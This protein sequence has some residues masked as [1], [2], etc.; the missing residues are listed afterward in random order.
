MT[1]NTK[2]KIEKPYVSLSKS[3]EES[4]IDLLSRASPLQLAR[5]YS[6]RVLLSDGTMSDVR[7]IV[8]SIKAVYKDS[9]DIKDI[10]NEI[11][12]EEAIH[13]CAEA[14]YMIVASTARMIIENEYGLSAA[15]S[16]IPF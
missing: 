1:A 4:A 3:L 2:E 7:E 9:R 16:D 14:R 6:K 12:R 11:A 10:I 8:S 5:Q 13:Q 15:Q